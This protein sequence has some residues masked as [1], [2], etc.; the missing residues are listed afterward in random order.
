MDD[1]RKYLNPRPAEDYRKYLNPQVLNK[2]ASLEIKARLIVEGFISGLHK[3][4]YHGFSV[5]FAQHREY[6]PGDDIRYIDWKVYGRSNRYYIKEY[7]E[8]TN[9]VSYFVLDGSASMQY[10]STNMSK[11]EYGCH[12]VAALSYL[13]LQQR[14]ATGLCVFDQEVKQFL[15]PSSNPNYL[16]DIIHN[17]SQITPQE[18][19]NMEPVF[20]AM[21]ERFKKRGLVVII[22]DLF[23]DVDHILAGLRHLRHRKHDVIIMHIMDPDEVNFPLQRLT[24]FE[25]LEDINSK[26]VVNPRAVKVAYLEE[27]NNFILSLKTGCIANRVDYVQITTDQMMDVSL[28][29]YLVNRS[30]KWQV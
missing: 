28:T 1:Y 27:L 11:Y 21:A 25:G 23:D 16:K 4:P 3:S 10:R 7:E 14:D 13:I 12:I 26:V 15:A 22:S 29:S 24:M 20:H 5:E 30:S 19:T 2:I 18:K 9:L 17:I 6:V 8:E